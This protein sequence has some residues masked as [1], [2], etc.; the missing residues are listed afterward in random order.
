MKISDLNL[1][2]LLRLLY[3]SQSPNYT[4]F[5]V[6]TPELELDQLWIAVRH[7]ADVGA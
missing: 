5:H 4:R 1:R 2:E 6:L 7:A 3:A